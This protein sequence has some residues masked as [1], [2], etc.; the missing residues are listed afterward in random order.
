MTDW[1]SDEITRGAFDVDDPDEDVAD[2]DDFEDE[3]PRR[4]QKTRRQGGSFD[5]DE[6]VADADDCEE[7]DE[8][9]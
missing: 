8:V 9:S 6:D 2:D 3:I 1:Y 7:D 4:A 5:V